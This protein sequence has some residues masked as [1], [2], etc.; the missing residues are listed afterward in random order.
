MLFFWHKTK[1]SAVIQ[2]GHDQAPEVLQALISARR[3]ID[4]SNFQSLYPWFFA[5]IQA[6]LFVFASSMQPRFPHQAN[7]SFH[8][9]TISLLLY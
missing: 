2:L 8:F 1:K 3:E 6:F 5:W 4:I 9:L 7:A